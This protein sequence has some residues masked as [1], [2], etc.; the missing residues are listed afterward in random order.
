MLSLTGCVNCD[1]SVPKAYR[2]FLHNYSVGDTIY[3]ESN[4]GDID[5]MLIVKYD[6]TEICGQGL[7]TFPKKHF[8]Y[9]IKHL[10]IN[11]WIFGTGGHQDGRTEV[12]Y[13]EL[14]SLGKSFD[15]KDSIVYSASVNYR[16]FGGKLENIDDLIID[17][18]F[19]DLGV[20]EYWK[21]EKS[22]YHQQ[23]VTPDSVIHRVYWSVKYGLT[24]YEY[25]NGEMYKIRN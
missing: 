12:Y 3:F 5:T 9:E 18:T 25:G 1:F 20:K 8:H 19:K 11:N 22:N 2:L 24:G 7:M 21:I 6:T 14:V 17:S 10:P 16:E 23:G 4:L 15:P 13:Q